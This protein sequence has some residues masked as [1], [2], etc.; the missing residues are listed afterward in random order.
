MSTLKLT[1]DSGGGT[2]SLKAP[3]STTSNGA[4]ELLLP[5]A[6]GS[7]GQA[8]TTNGSGQL[9]FA[10]VAGGKI[11]QVVSTS[12]STR[13]SSGTFTFYNYMTDSPFTCTI[14]PSSSSSKILLH[15][16][17]MGEA[18]VDSHQINVAVKRA[19]SGGSSTTIQSNAGGNYNV[20]IGPMNESANFSNNESTP[21]S[22]SFSGLIDT[23]NTT[24]AIT[25]T[26]QI[27]KPSTNATFYYN[28]TVGGSNHH[29]YERGLSW[30][31]AM[32][33]AA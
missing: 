14:T 12:D 5:V 17:L 20:G 19:I 18:T 6:D 9:A 26:I 23:P 32:E 13:T 21:A 25:Y 10:D 7:N 1:A 11:L 28:R 24:S 3:A 33:I 22:W 27:R 8:I 15:G 30:I 16:F 4:I 2:V 31:T 29:S